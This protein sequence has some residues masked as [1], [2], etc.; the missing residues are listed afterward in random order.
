MYRG[1]T[2]RTTNKEA[3]NAS[4]EVQMQSWSCMTTRRKS[5]KLKRTIRSHL[6]LPQRTRE[7]L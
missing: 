5:G 6:R 3:C 1:L 7:L 4:F 2:M